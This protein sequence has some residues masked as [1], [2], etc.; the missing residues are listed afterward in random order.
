VRGGDSAPRRRR[1]RNQNTIMDPP[2]VETFL[3]F[4]F[5]R[6]IST[7]RPEVGE[8]QNPKYSAIFRNI[9]LLPTL[10]PGK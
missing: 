4:V 2:V 3:V 7:R 10:P 6:P 8:K 1:R 9:K 5:R